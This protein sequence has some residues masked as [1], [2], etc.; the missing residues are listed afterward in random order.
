MA[1]GQGTIVD[2]TKRKKPLINPNKRSSKIRTKHLATG[3]SPA[4]QRPCEYDSVFVGRIESID[5][6]AKTLKFFEFWFA[7]TVELNFGQVHEDNYRKA[8]ALDTII[9]VTDTNRRP[10][11]IRACKDV[12]LVL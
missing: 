6:K 7:E 3:H 8:T 11:I 5:F 1:K 12:S 10:V 9:I 4:Q 2:A